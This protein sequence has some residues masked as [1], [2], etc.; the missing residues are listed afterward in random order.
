[1]NYLRGSAHQPRIG[2]SLHPSVLAFVVAP[3]QAD[4]VAE[5]SG[6]VPSPLILESLANPF[7][8][9]IVMLEAAIMRRRFRSKT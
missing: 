7:L 6:V 5:P 8:T 4:Q 9:P 2:R 3:T 1:M